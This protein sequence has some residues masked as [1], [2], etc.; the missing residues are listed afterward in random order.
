MDC[1]IVGTRLWELGF[2]P[3]G[4]PIPFATRR[5]DQFHQN[6]KAHEKR[7]ELLGYLSGLLIAVFFG[8]AVTLDVTG[9]RRNEEMRIGMN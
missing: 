2:G 6:G 5:H 1:E 4:G 8:E 3:I 9:R 7:I